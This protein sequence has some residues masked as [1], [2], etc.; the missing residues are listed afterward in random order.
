MLYWTVLFRAFSLR[1]VLNWLSELL[2]AVFRV[3]VCSGVFDYPLKQFSSLG[4]HAG[5]II[6]I[7]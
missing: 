5:P 4:D 7:S 6:K 3:N 2:E 1:R